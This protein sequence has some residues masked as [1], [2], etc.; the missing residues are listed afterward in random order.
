M[1]SE[2]SVKKSNVPARDEAFNRAKSS[3][4]NIPNIIEEVNADEDSEASSTTL[5][6]PTKMSRVPGFMINVSM[7]ILTGLWLGY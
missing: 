3:T 2:G 7:F 4:S 6:W 5:I 1:S